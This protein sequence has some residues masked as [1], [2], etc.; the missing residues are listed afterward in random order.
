MNIQLENP[1]NLKYKHKLQQNPI[2]AFIGFTTIKSVYINQDEDVFGYIYRHCLQLPRLIL[3]VGK[4][5][6]DI[7]VDRRSEDE[8][9]EKVN[10]SVGEY[11]R[12]QFFM[13]VKNFH[14][15]EFPR[16]FKYID[17]NILTKKDLLDICRKY[18][19]NISCSEHCETC[20]YEHPF[21]VLYGVGLLGIIKEDK[22]NNRRIQSFLPPEKCV[23]EIEKSILPESEY[24]L[25]HP[26]LQKVI[27]EENSK[28]KICREVIV[29]DGYEWPENSRCD[30]KSTK[31][32]KSGGSS[33]G[34][35]ILSRI[36][37]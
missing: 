29:G 25:I 19:G 28:Y 22:V 3:E 26:S 35:D 27:E 9:R 24:Y 36:Y 33:G 4:K 2:E 15:I 12:N 10:E 34:G 18:N 31:Q 16:L 7:E 11:I 13:E 37:R 8:I 5:I 1:K 17:R 20:R 6:A 14:N 23:Y 32:S 30:S 21:C